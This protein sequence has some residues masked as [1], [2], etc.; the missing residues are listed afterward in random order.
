MEIRLVKNVLA[1]NEVLAD[2]VRKGSRKLGRL[3]VNFMSSPPQRSFFIFLMS[4]HFR[5]PEP[6]QTVSGRI[7]LCCTAYKSPVDGGPALL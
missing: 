7:N 6:C 1:E 2:E 3:I 4:H 5:A